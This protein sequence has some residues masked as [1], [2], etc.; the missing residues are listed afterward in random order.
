MMKL[1]FSS[2]S[3]FKESKTLLCSGERDR[4]QPSLLQG[5]D[6]C[7]RFEESGGDPETGGRPLHREVQVHP[8]LHREVQVH[9][10]LDREVQV[11]HPLHREV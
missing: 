10:P 3:R 1:T 2:E 4:E 6:E 5:S 7:R 9:H 8:L 11:H